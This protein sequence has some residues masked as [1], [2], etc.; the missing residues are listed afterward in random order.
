M[1]KSQP[2]L[3]FKTRFEHEVI[4]FKISRYDLRFDLKYLRLDMKGLAAIQLDLELAALTSK[5]QQAG[6]ADL[7]PQHLS[8]YTV[9]GFVCESFES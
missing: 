7:R 1:G 2:P 5:H 9:Y 8:Y 4:R 3:G 6:V